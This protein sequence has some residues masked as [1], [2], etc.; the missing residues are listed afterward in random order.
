M[1]ITKDDDGRLVGWFDS[2][3]PPKSLLACVPI[4]T[5]FQRERWREFGKLLASYHFQEFTVDL[6]F[7]QNNVP[8][9]S[10]CQETPAGARWDQS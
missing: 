6:I 10:T 7:A 8:L 5:C 1:I 4:C 2:W 9:A 3:Q